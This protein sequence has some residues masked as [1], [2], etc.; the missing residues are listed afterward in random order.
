VKDN[1]EPGTGHILL[2]AEPAMTGELS[3][4]ELEKVAGGNTVVIALLSAVYV[5]A[6]ASGAY[7][8]HEKGW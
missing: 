8:Y 4:Q 7:M 5:T 6:L 2:P 1:E 3:D